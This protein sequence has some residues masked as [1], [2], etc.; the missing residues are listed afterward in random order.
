MPI[1]LWSFKQS[2][3]L[4]GKAHLKKNTIFGPQGQQ[5]GGWQNTNLL[6][7]ILAGDRDELS[8][9]QNKVSIKT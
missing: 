9:L 6:N 3:R 5:G 2:T 7:Q 1:P 8:K 4:L